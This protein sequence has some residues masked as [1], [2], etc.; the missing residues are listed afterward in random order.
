MPKHQERAL[1]RG[2]MQ[3]AQG[4]YNDIKILLSS[5]GVRK[6]NLER[7]L[8]EHEAQK[9]IIYVYNGLEAQAKDWNAFEEG[10]HCQK[11]PC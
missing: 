5:L 11:S 6:K 10:K 2:G 8:Y 4:N 3:R 7:L 9:L 1:G